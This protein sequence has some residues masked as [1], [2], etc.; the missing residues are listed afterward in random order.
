[1]EPGT[2]ASNT[3]PSSTPASG[4]GGVAGGAAGA[5]EATTAGE[6]PEA[7]RGGISDEAKSAHGS[8]AGEMIQQN[9]LAA[10]E[11]G[12]GLQARPGKFDESMPGGTTTRG[13]GQDSIARRLVAQVQNGVQTVRQA[14][15]QASNE[16]R[17]RSHS[18]HGVVGESKI[19]L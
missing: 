12:V 3:S 18:R 6:K 16:L 17:Q 8:A 1:M 11:E 7:E 10:L 19:Q 14:L 2:G 13:A 5:V 9:P 15:R 4:R